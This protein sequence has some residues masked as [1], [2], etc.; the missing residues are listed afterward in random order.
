MNKDITQI[1]IS[2]FPSIT[3]KQR[4]VWE[5]T[6]GLNGY[7]SMKAKEIARKLE[8]TPNSVYVHR[9]RVKKMLED[10]GL[11]DKGEIKPKRIIY[12]QQQSN[13]LE[14]LIFSLEKELEEYEEEE[15]TIRARLDKIEKEKP[16]IE[17]AIN[18]F[19]NLISEDGLVA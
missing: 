4:K 9:R 19:R 10:H 7:Q 13:R 17:S 11:I 3:D 5:M 16:E 8:M 15:K 14:Y 1:D 18:R 12:P 2:D 6:Y